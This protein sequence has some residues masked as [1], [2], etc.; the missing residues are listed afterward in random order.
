MAACMNNN[1]NPLKRCLGDISHPGSGMK[2]KKLCS[3]GVGSRAS[4]I[5]FSRRPSLAIVDEDLTSISS[6]DVDTDDYESSDEQ[7]S[8]ALNQMK[9][10]RRASQRVQ[11]FSNCNPKLSR[12]VSQYSDTDLED[13]EDADNDEE[14]LVGGGSS[15]GVTRRVPTHH[16]LRSNVRSFSFT[17]KKNDLACGKVLSQDSSDGERLL[18]L[19]KSAHTYGPLGCDTFAPAASSPIATSPAASPGSACGTNNL[20]LEKDKASRAQCFEYLVGAID[21]AW[22]SYCDATSVVEDE[23]YGYST[24]ELIASDYDDESSNAANNNIVQNAAPTSDDEN[25]TDLTDYDSDYDHKVASFKASTGPSLTNSAV[26]SMRM[27]IM[28]TP[29]QTSSLSCSATSKPSICDPRMNPS[30]CKLQELKERLTK[31]KYF[32]QDLVDSDDYNDMLTFWK[33]WDMIKYATIELV[34]EDDDDEVVE[35]TIDE[36]EGGRLFV[37]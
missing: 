8:Y 7:L 11:S 19:A 30:S 35:S 26:P 18:N 31:A 23:V 10:K 24:P 16:R 28:N 27:S 29:I 12:A 20:A 5:L 1:T 21:A 36:L 6:S 13:D 37:Q 2:V 17:I 9:A 3:S 22:A 25:D 32:L 33:R 4:S 34:E 14:G 15:P